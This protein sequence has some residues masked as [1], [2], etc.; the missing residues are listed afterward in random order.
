MPLSKPVLNQVDIVAR[1]FD[2]TLAFYRALGI[3]VVEVPRMP[4]SD[5]RHAEVTLENGFVVHVDNEALAR[6]YNA[7]WRGPGGGT[8][9][10]LGCSVATREE[11]DLRYA[12]LV[13]AGYEGRQAPYDAFWGARY[14][15]VADPDGVEVGIMSPPDDA[16]RSWPPKESPVA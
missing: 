6:V 12:A 1:D 3:D 10:L 11:V 9:A 5:I 2:A 4:G 13:A 14:A 16:K 7:G 8:R 15:I